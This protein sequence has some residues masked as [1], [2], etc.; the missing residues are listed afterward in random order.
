MF[1]RR[2]TM[3]DYD[4]TDS[5]LPSFVRPFVSNREQLI[6]VTESRGSWYATISICVCVCCLTSIFSDERAFD[7]M[8]S[9][10]WRVSR[11]IC[12]FYFA[13]SYD[14]HVH[15]D[16]DVERS[17]LTTKFS[18]SFGSTRCSLCRFTDVCCSICVLTLL[19]VFLFKFSRRF[20]CNFRK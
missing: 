17:R 7:K 3:R 8:S 16:V 19:S 11:S 2:L 4:A 10:Y 9:Q 15:R 5:L 1:H 13:L 12:G 20:W 14:W 18:M 6:D